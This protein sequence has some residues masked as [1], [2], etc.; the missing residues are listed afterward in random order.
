MFI[1]TDGGAGTTL[2]VNEGTVASSDFNAA[3]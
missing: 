1:K 2:Y 3:I